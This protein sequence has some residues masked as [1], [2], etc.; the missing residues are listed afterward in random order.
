MCSTWLSSPCLSQTRLVLPL[1]SDSAEPA[2]FYAR[3]RA[4]HGTI[5]SMRRRTFLTTAATA[6][7]AALAAAAA[8]GS[9]ELDEISLS[10]L[11]AGLQEGRW[12]SKRLLGL[13]LARIDA[14]D[15][16][17]PKL[18][19]IIELNPDAAA[20]ADQLDREGKAGRTRGPLHG[21]PVLIK[22]N[23]DT[24]DRMS[25]SAG[26]LALEGWH[27]SKDAFV[28]A[29]LRVAGALIMGKTHLREWANLDRK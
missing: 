11:A 19:S 1:I 23:I 22:D 3:F 28:A 24:A 7:S 5:L 17:G 27:P 21:I 4:A 12:T 25:T 16:H 14:I 15:R 2:R 13:Y 26:S 18:N 8:P 20:L 6:G 29:R 9:F 10:D